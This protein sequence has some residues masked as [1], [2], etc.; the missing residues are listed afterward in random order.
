MATSL[1]VT[2]NNVQHRAKDNSWYVLH[3]MADSRDEYAILD[4]WENLFEVNTVHSFLFR[5]LF[6][7]FLF[8]TVVNVH[9]CVNKLTLLDDIM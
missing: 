6:E 8:A 1:I 5:P 2:P 9:L 7:E 4:P 3:V